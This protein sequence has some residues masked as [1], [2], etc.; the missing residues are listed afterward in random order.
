MYVFYIY[1]EKIKNFTRNVMTTVIV[2]NL[3]TGSSTCHVWQTDIHRDSGSQVNKHIT[4]MERW[5]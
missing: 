5:L 4:H 3:I 2:S 1:I